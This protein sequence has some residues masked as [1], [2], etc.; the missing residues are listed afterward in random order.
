M[1]RKF[2]LVY[3]PAQS[4]AASP[5]ALTRRELREAERRAALAVASTSTVTA[6]VPELSRRARRA[7]ESQ[8]ALVASAT[9]AAPLA[10]STNR[11][12]VASASPRVAPVTRVDVDVRAAAAPVTPMVA[13]TVA[14]AP[15]AAQAAQA[16]AVKAPTAPAV[17]AD[18]PILPAVVIPTEVASTAA[19][20]PVADLGAPAD[21]DADIDLPLS[22]LRN[23][24]ALRPVA[25]T[26]LAS[27]RAFVR[28]KSGATTRAGRRG[29]ALRG[30]AGLAALGFAATVA[31]ASTLP[32]AAA[33]DDE[34]TQD[35][36]VGEAGGAQS[37]TA[38]GGT[39]EVQAASA[40]VDDR[41]PAYGVA[42]MGSA[43]AY[44]MTFGVPRPD[45]A[46]YSNSLTSAVQWP[47]PVGVV[48]SDHFGD[49][50][51][52]CS[53]CS[54][55]HKG[56]DFTP[57]EGTPIGSIAAGRV[58]TVQPAD[59]GGLGVHVTV[60]H[61]ID[62]ERIVSVYGHMLEGSIAVEV[63]QI[64]NVGDEV[65]KVGNT[66]SSTGAHLHLEIHVGETKVDPY[67]YLTEHNVATTVVDRPD[68]SVST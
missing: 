31:V 28:V 13:S 65:G 37:F 7:A 48:I 16:P 20:T 40:S 67:A 12:R 45:P 3:E 6:P 62:G 35:A 39:A 10:A 15:A 2:D 30:G 57:G 52:P 21:T 11:A 14:E 46:A 43:T 49:R 53:G 55:D 47:F 4:Q 61:V 24:A 68:P 36:I 22:F 54:S 19:I 41:A 27:K 23:Q 5:A 56:V 17:L 58:L 26:R 50:V 33:P 63:G 60:E 66:G 32:A 9:P 59:S 44:N 64:I 42:T 25:P 8:A 34:S 51:S 18:A 1:R 29:A 38:G